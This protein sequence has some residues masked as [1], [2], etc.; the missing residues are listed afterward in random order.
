[1]RNR[2]RS[3]WEAELDRLELDV[4]RVE[5]LLQRLDT[6]PLE[7]WN[8]IAVPGPMPAELADRAQHLLDR[9]EHVTAQLHIALG[10]AHRQLAYTDRVVDVVGAGGP[11]PVYLDLEA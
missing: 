5:R 1:M 4:V 10:E 3:A 6:L 11:A 7:P 2:L 9:Q 8:P